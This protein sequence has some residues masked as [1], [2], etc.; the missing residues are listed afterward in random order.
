[1]PATVTEVSPERD[2]HWPGFG[3]RSRARERALCQV[4]L[5]RAFPPVSVPPVKRLALGAV[6]FLAL[7][8]PSLAH[9]ELVPGSAGAMDSL[10]A[11]GADG[12]PRVAFVAAGGSIVF[13]VRSADGSWA[14]QTVPTPAGAQALVGLELGS[15]GAVLLIQ[16]TDG[17]RLRLAE[18]GAAGWQVRTIATAPRNGGLGL[19]GLAIGHDGRPVIAYA[20][21][22]QTRQSFLRLVHEDASGRLI[23]EAVTRKGFPPSTDLPT[24]T[25]VVLPSGAVRIV[26]A[27]SGATIEWSRTKNHKDWTGQFI[28]ANALGMPGGIVRAVA[29]PAGGVW[30]SWTELFPTYDESHLVLAQNLNGQH[31]TILS[32]HA[33]LV[34]LALPLAGPELAADDYVD[35]EGARTV[36]AGLVLDTQG[37]TVELAGDL[38]GYAVDPS[39][40]RHY[41]LLDAAGSEWYRAPTPPTASVELSAAVSGAAFL[42]SGRV[43]GASGGTVEIWRE[44]QT[45]AELLTTL[46]LAAD[47]TFA[48][49]DTPPQRPLTYRAVYHDANGLPLSSLVRSVLGA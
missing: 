5:K 49:T 1:V 31:T 2:G 35:L 30:S 36:Y 38:Q 4:G 26:E 20:S 10:L 17:S 46:P 47:G 48:L 25:P 21:L 24:V 13:A 27:Y 43:T 6:L 19:G 32:R 37:H 18:Q 9:A 42:L 34:S 14:E 29:D 15:T 22:L 28:Y 41:L 3:L 8:L 16:A 39:G 7:T 44:T 45:G 11:V 40:A 12:M 23:G 33:F